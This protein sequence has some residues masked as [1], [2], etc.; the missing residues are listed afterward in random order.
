MYGAVVSSREDRSTRL[1][2]SAGLTRTFPQQ[3]PSHGV[4]ALRRLNHHLPD[5]VR[6]SELVLNPQS[7]RSSLDCSRRFFQSMMLIFTCRSSTIARAL[8]KFLDSIRRSFARCLL[9]R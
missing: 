1:E 8:H 5:L 4:S 3:L 2:L 7:F 9:T 6:H